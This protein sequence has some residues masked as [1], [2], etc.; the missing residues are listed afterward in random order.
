MSYDYETDLG[1]LRDQLRE[2]LIMSY[3]F[4]SLRPPPLLLSPPAFPP[5]AFTCPS[6]RPSVL[7]PPGGVSGVLGE[8]GA[9]TPDFNSGRNGALPTY[10]N[11][12]VS[13]IT[14]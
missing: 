7:V 11:G 3:D 1:R 10:P 12:T 6:S 13:I 5:L 2:S 4:G 14:P 8:R 9:N